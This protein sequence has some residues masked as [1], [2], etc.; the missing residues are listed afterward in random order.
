MMSDTGTA[1][2]YNETWWHYAWRRW[3]ARYDIGGLLVDYGCGIGVNGQI[4]NRL[5][6]RRV[7]GVDLDWGCL[8]ASRLR[9]LNVLQGDLSKPLGLRP[10]AADIVLLIHCLEHLDDGQALLSSVAATLRPGGALVVVTPDWPQVFPH[11]YDD[12]THRRPYTRSG[13]KAM[14]QAAGFQVRVLL[15]HN[16]GYRVRRTPLWRMF[17]RLCFTG[18]A[19][20]AIAERTSGAT[21]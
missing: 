14:L 17:P 15:H 9:G 12:P 5:S 18:D 7:I 1:F 16:V 3:L 4:L 19:L 8:L 2:P 11:F 6:A 20:F 21:P 13:L 10:G